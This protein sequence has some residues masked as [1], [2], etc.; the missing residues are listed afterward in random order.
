MAAAPA[1]GVTA[2]VV[3]GVVG[4]VVVRLIASVSRFTKF[5]ASASWLKSS[6]QDCTARSPIGVRFFRRAVV[7]FSNFGSQNRIPPGRPW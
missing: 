1:G 7:V 6:R 2:G 3:V 5:F 4:V